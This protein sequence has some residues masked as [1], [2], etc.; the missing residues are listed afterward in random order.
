M[1]NEV[2]IKIP[3]GGAILGDTKRKFQEVDKIILGII[4]VLLF[5]LVAII[6]SV[7][8]I[9]FDQMRF[10]NV[11]YREY[12]GRLEE[13]NLIIEDYSQQI[14]LNNELL[15]RIETEGAKKK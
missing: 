2:K 3:S 9:F 8:G 14:K 11:A 4:F 1:G 5:S 15:K 6:I 7:V 12:T 10:N 13:R